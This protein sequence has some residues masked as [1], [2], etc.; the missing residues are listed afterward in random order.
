MERMKFGFILKS[1]LG[2]KSAVNKTIIV[3]ITVLI[4]KLETFE[5]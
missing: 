1:A 5:K 2:K 3:L 4:S